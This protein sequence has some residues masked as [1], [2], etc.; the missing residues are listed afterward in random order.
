MTLAKE[1]D[2]YSLSQVSIN[3]IFFGFYFFFVATIHV[4]HVFLIE[5]HATFSRYF[6]L[7][8]AIAQCAIETLLLVL[9]ANA[10]KIFFRAKAMAIYCVVVFFLMLTHAIDFPLVRFMDMSFWYAL[11][12]ISAESPRNF[13]ELLYASNVSLIVWF[14]S[15][16]LG[17][18]ILL[19][20]IYAYRITERWTHRRP[21]VIHY[22]LLAAMLCT[23]CLFL[24]SWD[25]STHKWVGQSHYDLYQKTLPWKSTLFHRHREFLSLLHPLKEPQSQESLLKLAQENALAC[26]TKP[27]IFLF[28]IE[29]L[30]EDFIQANNAPYLHQFKQDH[31]SFDLALSNANATQLTWFSLFYSQFPFYWEKVNP[32]Q[33][34]KGSIPLGLLKEM[35]YKILCYSSARLGYYQMDER[36]FGE[37]AYLADE[38]IAFGENHSDMPY[39]RD[40]KTIDALIE[41]MQSSESGGRLFLV[42]LDA[43]HHD[44]SWP[45]DESPFTPYAEKINYFKAAVSSAGLEMIKNRYRN[46][47][48]YVDSLFGTFMK[49]F[50]R[51]SGSDE[52]VIV[53]TGDHGEEFYEEG[54]LF[55]ASSLSHAQTH[56]PLYYRFGKS[57]PFGNQTHSPMSCHMDIFPTL[58]HYLMGNE[59]LK[60]VFQG[61]SVF[62]TEQ[63]PFTVTA[64]FNASRSPCEFSI[65]N[66]KHKLIATFSDERNIFNAKGLRII[67]LKNEIGE[68]VPHDLN[69]LKEH[70]GGALDQIFTP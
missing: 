31:I 32:K 12:F 16:V 69:S 17:F 70:F 26:E 67:S 15:G 22:P 35:G 30:R 65:H 47:L 59:V 68:I 51:Y 29:S 20:G 45:Q 23:L 39:V 61:H 8:H 2:L 14:F 60:E 44:Y 48:H 66:G 33:W 3:Y 54:H 6:F 38:M 25:Y 10:I 27:D 52:A 46:A 63:S 43:T 13:L 7:S 28:I 53:I 58:F 37:N 41:K 55:H 40:K 64:R 9:F 11:N 34:K 24:M 4:Y 18:A 19:S 62:S 1:N 5:P 56:I 57:N 36:I 21:L 50:N 42:F 49:S